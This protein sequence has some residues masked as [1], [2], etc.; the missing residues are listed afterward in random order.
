[1][2]GAEDAGV[3]DGRNPTRLD[4]VVA[5]EPALGPTTPNAAESSSGVADAAVAA[6][7][8]AAVVEG[9]TFAAD[10]VSRPLPSLPALL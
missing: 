1:V 6:S 4:S 10:A 8:A 2:D 7:G 5:A 9:S 3:V